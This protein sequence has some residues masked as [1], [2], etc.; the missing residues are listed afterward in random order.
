MKSLKNIFLITTTI[1]TFFIIITGC[2]NN[3][4]I[5]R[6]PILQKYA[7]WI[8]EGKKAIPELKD[9]L[10]DSNWKVRSHALIAIGKINDRSLTPLVFE[11]LIKDESIPVKNCSV[12]VLGNL[13]SK[14]SVPVL[15]SLLK[16]NTVNKDK[17]S[18][19]KTVLIDAL[20]QIGDPK[21]IDPL[22][23]FLYNPDKQ[24]R[25]RA[26]KAL[27]EIGDLK[28]SKNCLTINRIL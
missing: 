26:L 4:S 18:I 12:I 25:M 1:L 6:D 8:Q 23:S 16:N 21:A 27:V 5:E 13:K 2:G 15:I 24:M 7:R 3:E 28:V 11:R 19:S 10:K 14:E 20:G 17:R 9:A 22:Y